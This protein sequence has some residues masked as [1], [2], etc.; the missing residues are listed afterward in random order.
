[1]LVHSI[2]TPLEAE[3][4][5]I[6]RSNKIAAKVGPLPVKTICVKDKTRSPEELCAVRALYTQMQC[7]RTDSKVVLS[8]A[9]DH[10]GISL[11]KDMVRQQR[12]H[13]VSCCYKICAA[14]VKQRRH[15][16][17]HNTLHMILGT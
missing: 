3:E 5:V 1:M 6:S 16:L 14:F 9:V 8:D 2:H 10:D 12:N 11:T 7:K 17:R 4:S 13:G 15:E